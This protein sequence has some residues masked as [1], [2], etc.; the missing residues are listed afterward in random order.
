MLQ[1]ERFC[2]DKI[3]IS[4]LSLCLLFHQSGIAQVAGELDISS[5]TAFLRNTPVP[6]MSGFEYLRYLSYDGRN[7]NFSCLVD[8]GGLSGLNK[9]ITE[10]N[11]QTLLNYFFVGISLPND[12][13]W[14][15]LRPDSQDT[16]I[17]DNLARTD[18]G[19]ILLEADLQLKKDTALFSSPETPE[20]KEYW[21][22]LYRKAEALFGGDNLVI[23]TITRPWIVPGEIIIRESVDNA[24]IY[25]ATLKVMLEHDHL[26]DSGAY[27]L[28]DERLKELN[29]YSSCLL[30]ALIIPKL[31]HDVNTAKRY[32]SLRQ[33]YYSL[34]LA[35]WFKA[36][37]SGKGGIYA[38]FIDQGDLTGLT[39]AGPW[40]KEDYFR[41]YRESFERGEYNLKTAVPGAFGQVI[42][43][44]L[45]GGINFLAC[46]PELFSHPLKPGQAKTYTS[47]EGE[48]RS[49]IGGNRENDGAIFFSPELA[50]FI[51][52]EGKMHVVDTTQGNKEVL[53]AVTQPARADAPEKVPARSAGSPLKERKIGS[54]ERFRP[55]LKTLVSAAFIFGS[56]FV[57]G[58]AFAHQFVAKGLGL[59]SVPQNWSFVNPAENTLWGIARDVLKGNG[60]LEPG[61][62]EVA[63]LVRKILTVNS[64]IADPDL[65][66]SGQHIAIPQEYATP[67]AIAYLTG[68]A[69]PF[70]S[71]P[72]YIPDMPRTGPLAGRG[73][74]DTGML[75]LDPLAGR[76]DF[77]RGSGLFENLGQWLASPYLLIGLGILAGG[78]VSYYLYRWWNKGNGTDLLQNSFIAEEDRWYNQSKENRFS[79]ELV[80][81]FLNQWKLSL[82]SKKSGFLTDYDRVTINN[83]AH[84]LIRGLPFTREI[85]DQNVKPLVKTFQE[86]TK[87]SLETQRRLF[88]QLRGHASMSDEQRRSIEMDIEK[89]Q[90]IGTYALEYE[91]NANTAYKFQMAF[92]Y[93]LRKFGMMGRFYT[94][95]VRCWYGLR[96]SSKDMER[97]KSKIHGLF[98]YAQPVEPEMYAGKENTII[99]D[100]QQWFDGLKVDSSFLLH[101]EKKW[102]NR[103]MYGRFGGI[104]GIIAGSYSFMNMVVTLSPPATIVGWIGLGAFFLGWISFL[105]SWAVVKL[106]KNPF[107]KEM[108]RVVEE[109]DRLLQQETNGR[110]TVDFRQ[111][112]LKFEYDATVGLL[113]KELPAD[114][115]IVVISGDD[116]EK[117]MA[118]VKGSLG[119]FAK[120]KFPVVYLFSESK[121][122]AQRFCELYDYLYYSQ[123][124]KDFTSRYPGLNGKDATRMKKAVVFVDGFSR[125]SGE[126]FKPLPLPPAKALG[127]P[128]T[129]IEYLLLKTI[130]NAGMENPHDPGGLQSDKMMV[131][132]SNG[133]PVGN[134]VPTAN[135]TLWGMWTKLEQVIDQKFGVLVPG[136][137]NGSRNGLAEVYEKADHA[138]LKTKLKHEPFYSFIDWKHIGDAEFEQSDVLASTGGFMF[139]LE[140]QQGRMFARVAVNGLKP[141]MERHIQEGYDNYRIMPF[142]II[143]LLRVLNS[144][145]FSTYTAAAV[146]SDD[147]YYSLED[148]EI[149]AFHEL[150]KYYFENKDTIKK[151]FRDIGYFSSYPLGSFYVRMDKSRIQRKRMQELGGYLRGHPGKA[152]PAARKAKDEVFVPQAIAGEVLFPGM[153]VAPSSSAIRVE[154]NPGQSGLGGIDL[155]SASSAF[156][157]TQGEPIGHGGFFPAEIPADDLEGRDIQHLIEAGIIPS[158]ERIKEYMEAKISKERLSEC[159]RYVRVWMRQILRLEEA[160]CVHVDALLP[161]FLGL[162]ENNGTEGLFR[163]NL[164]RL[165]FSPG[166]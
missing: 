73:D 26:K 154:K 126:L 109:Y 23:P 37:F 99:D 65:I 52:K 13:F 69:V 40:S 74:L 137:N 110:K 155:R 107:Y 72:P 163:E 101:L 66:F 8:K 15:N 11:A 124:F 9:R 19:M 95:F 14:V 45:S 115:A 82:R 105:L 158:L 77:D 93:K 68:Q 31:T 128:F 152:V 7:N 150:F 94:W 143:P 103:G 84:S 17:D 60:V 157:V 131:M 3:I 90:R 161:D 67:E 1:G 22:K 57:P 56:F 151:C 21:D 5:R 114:V 138:T 129:G 55:S 144:G 160:H 96:M 147:V 62:T 70:G 39:S 120:K 142:I 97:F 47:P 89:L 53:S 123:E 149:L 12:A 148:K 18:V 28:K 116:K 146:G 32:A 36:R 24:Y 98:K 111:A 49:L 135:V 58:L 117:L 79:Q 145:K 92:S 46:M 162:L 141:I 165:T 85:I 38:A 130:Q 6:G 35:Q 30:K 133:I 54:L 59:L 164:A 113:E 112:R 140:P 51:Y 44:Y 159:I 80:K 78:V 86:M 16:I 34:I 122:N 108:S 25:K 166:V 104:C 20:G 88:L 118:H 64:S 136:V 42:R 134:F 48:Q 139:S 50:E 27:D 102:K 76:G 63:N 71:A 61:N 75:P 87:L 83:I 2:V 156:V 81:T 127:R 33:V 153:S 43:T 10:N 91:D 4:A 119:I 132:F 100:W 125:N 41:Q 29:E 106:V 121:E